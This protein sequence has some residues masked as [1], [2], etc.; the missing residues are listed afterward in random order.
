MILNIL[1]LVLNSKNNNI[2]QNVV[3]LEIIK[4]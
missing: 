2:Q 3:T 4:F 1:E